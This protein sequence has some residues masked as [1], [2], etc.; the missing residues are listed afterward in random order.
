MRVFNFLSMAFE[1]YKSGQ[2]KYTRL[3]TALSTALVCGLGCL[4]L[5]VFL[6]GADFGLWVSTMVPVAIGSVLSGLA[7]WL[8]NKPIIADFMIAAEG[9]IKKVSWSTR[10]EIAVS[11]FVVVVVVI[12][13]SA[14]L[15]VTDFGF[16][17]FFM[18][19][20]G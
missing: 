17:L 18:W 10:K 20:L 11:T 8:V 2:G 6:D 12:S 5:Y 9:E 19:L 13:I 15:G 1:I 7:F 4:R 3:V 16:Q 14:I